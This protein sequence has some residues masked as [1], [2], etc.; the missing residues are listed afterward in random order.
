MDK[1]AAPSIQQTEQALQT[2]PAGARAWFWF[3]SSL[4]LTA[5]RLLIQPFNAT[6]GEAALTQQA[7]ALK[8]DRRAWSVRGFVVSD[9]RGQLTFVSPEAS[10]ALLV[11][12][13]AWVKPNLDA[14]PELARLRS[15]SAAMVSSDGRLGPRFTD[16]ALWVGVPEV[17]VPDTLRASAL[18]LDGLLA[19][20]TARFCL[21]DRGPAGRPAVVI[22]PTD[23]DAQ[24]EDFVA[25][26]RRLKRRSPRSGRMMRG[27]INSLPS[28]RICLSTSAPVSGWRAWAGG[29]TVEEPGLS[30][31]AKAPLLLLNGGRIAGVQPRDEAELTAL[32]DGLKALKTARKGYFWF[33]D[34]NASGA[35][36]LLVGSSPDAL[37]ASAR[38]HRGEGIS[39]RGQVR[40][41]DDGLVFKATPGDFDL[42]VG[43]ARTHS[44]RHPA[45]RLLRNA[46]L[47]H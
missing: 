2:L 16:P 26:V 7:E 35:A 36:M 43:F 45:M 3:C 5:P 46:H 28:G 9:A 41:T 25:A 40:L 44:S 23:S 1:S 27:I 19:G 11:Q 8:P 15:A 31:L 12:L 32:F 14:H 17:L 13:A 18:A 10:L 42:L 6:G 4:D 20:E 30:A 33:T 29:L 47:H 24:G 22:V 39:V 38:S 34:A 37:R 21:A